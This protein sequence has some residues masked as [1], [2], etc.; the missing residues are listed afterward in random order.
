[1]G[2][3][4]GDVGGQPGPSIGEASATGFCG[5]LRHYSIPPHWIVGGPTPPH[6]HL[7]TCSKICPKTCLSPSPPDF[8]LQAT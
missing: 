3:E 5:R 1:M 6:L 4:G 7:L 2:G 8:A